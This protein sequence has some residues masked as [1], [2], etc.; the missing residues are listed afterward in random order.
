M[1][2][3]VSSPGSPGSATARSAGTGRLIAA[4]AVVLLLAGVSLFVGVSDLDPLRVLTGT[5]TDVER[6]TL[7][8]SRL[9]RTISIVLAGASIAIVGLVMQMLVRNKFVEPATAGTS[10][11]A[12]FGLLVVTIVSP[13]MPLVGKM[14]VAAV[15]ALA[16][17]MLFLRILRSIPLRSVIVVPLVGMMLG[18]VIAAVTTFIAYRRQ[19]TQTLSSWLTGDFS[20]VIQNRYE[21]LWLVAIAGILVY[22]MADRFTVTGMGEEFTTNLGLNYRTAMNVGLGLVAVVTAL[23]IV[24]VGS[25]PFLG[26]VVPN[27]VSR[28]VGDNLRRS[29]PWVALLGAGFVLAC[30]ILGRIVR[31]PYE[32]PIGVVV[33]L[34]GSGVFLYLLLY[35]PRDRREVRARRPA[36][37]RDRATEVDA[38]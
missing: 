28:F 9:P 26:L 23:V 12:A 22:V 34:V 1:R 6:Q 8:V 35:E 36:R 2:V 7:V 31:F 16:G 24:V 13:G 11:S 17:T 3:T 21:L 25:L 19:M 18:A 15:F 33:G 4:V 32:V 27:I 29:L 5:L 10:E 30:D 38:R 20:G 14:V 37:A